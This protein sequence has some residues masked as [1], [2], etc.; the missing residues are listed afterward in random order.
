[1]RLLRLLSYSGSLL[2]V[3][4]LAHAQGNLPPVVSTGGNSGV[5]YAVD[6][7]NVFSGGSAVTSVQLDGS[8]SFD[9]NGTPVTFFWH[10]ECGFGS[11]DDPTSPTPVY[12][13][14]MTG[15]CSR[16]CWIAL[17]VSSGGQTTIVGFQVFVAD[18]TAPQLTL[19]KDIVGI[20]GDPTAVGATGFATAVDNCDP[21]PVVT[22]VDNS[23]A[24]TGPGQP[25]LMLE[26]TWTA[27]DCTG[28]Q[29]SG[30]QLIL[31]L[32]PTG[33]AGQQAN[34][35]FAPAQCPNLY[36]PL[37]KGT[38]DVLLLGVQGF[39]AEKV[40][41]RSVRM[42]LTSN[43]S[44]AIAPTSFQLKDLGSL[45]AANY[46]DCNGATLD[47][48]KDLRLR[49]PRSAVNAMLG[50]GGVQVGQTVDVMVIGNLASGKLFATRDVVTLQ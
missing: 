49:F 29:T 14:D 18:A 42:F 21:A 33:D 37:P 11:F 23:L 46:G 47:G 5:D 28:R 16:D 31:L 15:A 40:V 27:T 38:V 12:R 34:L 10:N 2:A 24:H 1:M 44:V 6:C 4:A 17:R 39:K 19:P 48:R 45:T 13:V 9:P 26:R 25:E 30:V 22:F 8:A 36:V 32:A 7:N 41:K 35:D 20:W 50:Q 3:G 43:P